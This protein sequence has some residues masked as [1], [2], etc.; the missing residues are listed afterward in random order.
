[1][2]NVVAV[3]TT[4]ASIFLLTFALLWRPQDPARERVRSLA[5]YRADSQAPPAPP[6]SRLLLPDFSG[7]ASAL[8]PARVLALLRRK[9]EMAGSTIPFNFFLLQWALLAVGLP[10]VFLVLFLASGSFSG[11]LVLPLLLL[12]ATGVAL[13]Y[14]WLEMRVRRRQ[15]IIW[16]SLP[17]AFDLITTM[18]EAGLGLDSALARVAEKVPGPF[19]AELRTA[20]REVA[21]GKPRRQALM[22][23]AERTGVDDLTTFVNAIV[24]AEQMGVSVGQVLRVQSEQM[25]IR[26]RQRAEQSARRAAILLIFPIIFCNLPALFIVGIGP[27]VIALM[28]MLNE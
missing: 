24:Q 14:V 27:T 18:V 9:L 2:L 10:G 1:M 3:A 25:R 26:R 6:L 13:P 12:G 20:I 8:L 19:A 15:N 17:D 5:R 11:G 21:L 4:F 23:M 16:K 22:D 7:L 28:K